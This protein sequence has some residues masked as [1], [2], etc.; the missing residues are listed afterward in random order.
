MNLKFSRKI[1]KICFIMQSLY[2]LI[3]KLTD[4]KEFITDKNKIQNII[5]TD[6]LE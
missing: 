4:Q 5:G 1:R 3:F 2:A 6:T